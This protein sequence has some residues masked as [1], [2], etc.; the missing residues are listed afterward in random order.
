MSDDEGD[1][2]Y[3]YVC[4]NREV[5]AERLIE[6]VVCKRFVHFKCKRIFGFSINTVKAKPYLCSSECKNMQSAG[7]NEEVLKEIRALT[8]SVQASIKETAYVRGALVQ[9]QEQM[10]VIADTNKSIEE[11]QNFISK[12]FEVLKAN[13]EAYK[14]EVH[15]LKQGNSKVQE[16]VSDLYAKNH[17]LSTRVDQ[18]ELELDRVNRARLTKNVVIMGLPTCENENTLALVRTMCGALGFVCGEKDVLQARHSA[19]G[20]SQQPDSGQQAAGSATNQKAHSSSVI[21]RQHK[22]WR[23]H[24]AVTLLGGN[25]RIAQKLD[26]LASKRAYSKKEQRQVRNPISSSSRMFAGR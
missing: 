18:L 19:R 8:E 4:G 26:L 10:K 24:D 13:L 15:E 1:H 23:T 16:C 3:C 14:Q 7:G 22:L 21:L 6:C 11:S 2:R 12:E 9:M 5:N 25:W 20:Q 17:E